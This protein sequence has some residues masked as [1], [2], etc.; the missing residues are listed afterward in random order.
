MHSLDSANASIEVLAHYSATPCADLS[1][2]TWS[3]FG[4]PT[5]IVSDV[6]IGNFRIF[7]YD[8]LNG[9]DKVQIVVAIDDEETRTW[10]KYLVVFLG[11]L[12]MGGI[13]GKL[14]V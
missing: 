8:F 1:A 9:P 7:A 11:G 5:Q 2:P 10:L 12:A 3:A 13:L 6:R 14:L 4:H